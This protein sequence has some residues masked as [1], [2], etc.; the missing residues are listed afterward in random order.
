MKNRLFK[1]KKDIERSEMAIRNQENRQ[2]SFRYYL[3]YSPIYLKN[4][5][6]KAR[7][8]YNKDLQNK[9]NEKKRR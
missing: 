2:E 9:L 8:L 7:E 6:R 5:F 1:L 4:L 3:L